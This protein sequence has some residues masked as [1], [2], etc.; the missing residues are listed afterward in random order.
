MDP[1]GGPERLSPSCPLQALKPLPEPCFIFEC[2][3]D[4]RG[5]RLKVE[6][7]ASPSG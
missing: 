2:V 1:A 7:E 3:E 6:D 5:W 4:R